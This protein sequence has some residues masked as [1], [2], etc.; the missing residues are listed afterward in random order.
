[1]RYLIACLS[2]FTC[3]F[4]DEFLSPY[5]AAYVNY[6]QKV[7]VHILLSSYVEGGRVCLGRSPGEA[8]SVVL[9]GVPS[10]QR[11]DTLRYRV[12]MPAFYPAGSLEDRDYQGW[13]RFYLFDRT[14]KVLASVSVQIGTPPTSG[15]GKVISS[16]RSPKYGR[17]YFGY[18]IMGRNRRVTPAFTLEHLH[19]R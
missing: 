15:V 2:L 13:A 14:W 3:A 9:A 11:K 18:D 8:Q 7:D 12:E 17:S 16:H 19:G 5:L 4:S 1:M 6:G 10:G